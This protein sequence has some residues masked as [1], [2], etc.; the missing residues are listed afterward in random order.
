VSS[1][2]AYTEKP[3]LEKTNKQTNK[4]QKT[5]TTTTNPNEIPMKC[6]ANLR[7]LG[8]IQENTY[9]KF[10]TEEIYK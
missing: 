9:R 5:T 6:S 4:P 8:E 1:R 3:C 2:T 10:K 7:E